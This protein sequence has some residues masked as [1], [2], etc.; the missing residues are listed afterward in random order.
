MVLDVKNKLLGLLLTVSVTPVAQAKIVLNINGSI[1]SEQLAPMIK[2][3]NSSPVKDEVVISL[4]S[5]GGDLEATRELLIAIWPRP[6]TCIVNKGVASAAYFILL[7]CD[8][9][10]Y[11]KDAVIAFHWIVLE[12]EVIPPA[13]IAVGTQSEVL[14]EQGGWDALGAY[15]MGLP[16]DFYL[17]IRNR[18]QL[19]KIEHLVAASTKKWILPISE[20]KV[21]ELL[22]K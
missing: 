12:W 17:I 16:Q 19:M 14:Y 15:V 8:R 10:Y 4:H 11:V 21:K 1:T 22:S 2:E 6:L 3:V 20:A 9:R 13:D 5:S 18:N 7:H